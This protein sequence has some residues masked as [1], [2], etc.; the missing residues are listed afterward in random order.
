MEKNK[1]VI[2]IVEDEAV[3][4]NALCDKFSR[5]GF[6]VIKSKNGKEGVKKAISE[7]PDLILMDIIMPVMDG[8]TALAKIRANK[9]CKNIPVIMLTN[10]SDSESV[11]KAGKSGVNDFLIKT[12]WTL[13][14]L[15]KKIRKI[16][17]K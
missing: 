14:D 2:L 11:E 5:E 6:K 7:Q 17:S 4:M 13:N 10:L 12:D 16:L 8:L 9:R 1:K 3:A 15:S